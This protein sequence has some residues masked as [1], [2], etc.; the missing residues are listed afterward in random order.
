MGKK[1]NYFRHSLDAH[2]DTKILV[3]IQKNGLAS[4]AAY[5]ILLEIYGRFLLN[6]DN[7]RIDQKIN[8]RVIS[9]ALGTRSDLTRKLVGSMAEVGLISNFYSTSDDNSFNLAI[10][11]FSKYFGKYE[12]DGPMN[13]PNKRKEKKIKEK[14]RKEDKNEIVDLF[15][16]ESIYFEYPRKSG[17]KKGIDLCLK[18]IKTQDDFNNLMLSVKNYAIVC[19][20]N[21]T[22]EKYIKHFST[23]MNCWEDY[24]SIENDSYK[25]RDQRLAE[26]F[27]KYPEPKEEDSELLRHINENKKK[28]SEVIQ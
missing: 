12:K 21:E 3:L 27:D 14:K 7:Q 4:Y 17:K 20:F 13:C 26:F 15:D 28:T 2:N 5:F 10:P 8:W 23:F 16:F 25:T 1:A 22:E 11:N 9:N 19:D 18:K 24:V 6:D